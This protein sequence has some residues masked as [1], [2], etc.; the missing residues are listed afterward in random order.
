MTTQAHEHKN[1]AWW[2]QDHESGWERAKVA[3]KRDWEQT[4]ADVS[5]GGQELDRDAGDTVKQAVGKQAIPP[6]GVPNIDWGSNEPAVRY[7]YGARQYY[8]ETEWN[9]QLESKL[10]T[11]YETHEPGAWEK[12]KH[13]VRRGWESVTQKVV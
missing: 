8:R 7:G 4:K 13:A 6:A 1:P 3:L 2:T 5:D 11:D 10:R 9:D 12:V